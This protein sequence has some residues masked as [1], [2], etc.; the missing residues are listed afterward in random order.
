M[1]EEAVVADTYILGISCFMHDS[2]ACILK[3][4]VVIAFAE[5]E[6]FNREK[7]TRKFPEH[8]ID[9]CLAEAG[10]GM[11]RV[12]YAG[13]FWKPW[14]GM[15]RRLFNLLRSYGYSYH[16][17]GL[18]W[19][20]FIAMLLV[21]R[22]LRIRY[23]YKGKFIFVSHHKAHISAAYYYSPFKDA[24]ILSIDGTGEY[25]TVVCAAIENGMQKV[26]SRSLYPNSLGLFYGSVTE[27]LGFRINCDEG[28][29]M[30]LSS[31]GK[32]AFYDSLKKLIR[33]SSKGVISVDRKHYNF[34][35]KE[36]LSGW[37]NLNGTGLKRG[38][39]E[40]IKQ[41]HEDLAASVQKVFE[42]TLLEL[43]KYMRGRTASDNL[44]LNG[45]VFLNC[46]AN[47][48]IV[49]ESGFKNIYI[50]PIP[51][52]AGTAI[53]AACH[54]YFEVLK[55]KNRCLLENI[56]LGPKY[57][58]LSIENVLKK[59]G[60]KY[61]K[62]ADIVKRT[63]ALLAANKVVGWFQGAM[64]GGPRA[65]GNR[66]ILASPI[67]E[68]MK[69]TLNNKV[70]HREPF[71]PFAPAVLF[72]RKDECF[73]MEGIESPYMLFA[74]PVKEGQKE[75]MPAIV[76]VDG[77]A[78]IQTV[79]QKDNPQFYSLIKEFNGLTGLPVIL[80]TSFNVKGEPIVCSPEDAVKCYLS[81]NIDVLCLG[82]YLIEK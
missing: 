16:R 30:G 1:K 46:V 32:P 10:I 44:C 77:T 68:N 72:E 54:I 81:T 80:N 79:R 40:P 50:F 14:K 57:S 39:L 26:I 62:T 27:L 7:H 23:G 5:E 82:E 33:V 76:H 38:C 13:F 19:R 41:A 60:L 22:T 25:E 21:P 56:C 29:V 49:R 65:L 63:A 8:A 55:K 52:D 74:L 15:L 67:S 42:D 34:D 11:D 66:S 70:K 36:P 17:I 69:D 64:E 31:Y 75:R 43:I 28:K 48:R 58:G 9:Y 73:E 61:E 78:R 59:Y 35:T 3:N 37:E 4:G 71:R 51:N 6:R 20:N 53:G 47:S 24:A 18:Y 45:G 12:A 2:S